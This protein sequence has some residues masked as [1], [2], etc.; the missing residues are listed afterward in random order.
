MCASLMTCYWVTRETAP[1]VLTS[2]GLEFQ[3]PAIGRELELVLL[4]RHRVRCRA[5]AG[6]ADRVEGQLILFGRDHAAVG[7]PVEPDE[8]DRRSP[9]FIQRMRVGALE[10]A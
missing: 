8:G 1:N 9:V 2:A 6:V 3:R 4:G 10:S 5:V 7:V